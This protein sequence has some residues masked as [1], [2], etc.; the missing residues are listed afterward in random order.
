MSRINCNF[1]DW[2]YPRFLNECSVWLWDPR[3]HF[4]ENCVLLK[5]IWC[6]CLWLELEAIVTVSL[7]EFWECGGNIVGEFHIYLFSE[8]F[9]SEGEDIIENL[10]A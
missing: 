4:K 2:H 9:F 6:L 5:C 8:C 7:D 3:A 1:P 10:T